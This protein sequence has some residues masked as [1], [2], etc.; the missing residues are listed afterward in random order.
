[1]DMSCF[2]GDDI[3]NGVC[4]W[5]STTSLA[6]TM[7]VHPHLLYEDLRILVIDFA[8]QSVAD[9]PRFTCLDSDILRRLSVALFVLTYCKL[10]GVS[11]ASVIDAAVPEFLYYR[12]P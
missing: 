9:F 5:A 6:H 1:M 7:K 10:A 8:P 4:E 12:A 2:F 3:N 11:N